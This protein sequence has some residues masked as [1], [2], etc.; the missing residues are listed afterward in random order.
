M[1][2]A[3]FQALLSV[4][5]LFASIRNNRPPLKVTGE[6]VEDESIHLQVFPVF[7]LRCFALARSKKRG[8]NWRCSC[9]KQKGQ[10]CFKSRP[11]VYSVPS[12][13]L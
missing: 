4:V 9:R 3:L 13:L 5:P 6:E 1:F 12:L 7:C 10:N 11:N 8:K 2:S